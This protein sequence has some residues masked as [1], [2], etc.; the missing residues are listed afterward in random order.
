[1]PS[2]GPCHCF[3]QAL[4][5]TCVS[6]VLVLCITHRYAAQI[7]DAHA[8]IVSVILTCANGAIIMVLMCMAV[9]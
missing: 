6:A 2:A 3:A 4:V 8:G 7:R 1:M 5:Y 9:L